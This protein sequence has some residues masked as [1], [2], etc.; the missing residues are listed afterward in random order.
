MIFSNILYNLARFKLSSVAR[1]SQNGIT[2]AGSANGLDGSSLDRLSGSTSA[3]YGDDGILYIS[4]AGNDR[5]VLIAPNSTTPIAVIGRRSDYIIFAYPAAI[6]VTQASIYV[7]DTGNFRVQKWS[8]DFYDPMTVAGISGVGGNSTEMALL[9]AAFSLFVDNYGNVFVSDTD[10]HRVMKFPSNSIS[11]T[12]GMIVAGIGVRGSNNNQL[13]YPMGIFVTNNGILY[14][15]D[16]KNHRIQK[17]IVGQT[18]GEIVGGTGT[19]GSS[20]SQLNSPFSVVV[21]SD[22]YMYITDQGNSRI[23]RWGPHASA[24]ECIVACSGTS[25]ISSNQL[26][27]PTTITFDSIGSMYVNDLSNNRVQKFEILTETSIIFTHE[28]SSVKVVYILGQSTTLSQSTTS[29][30]EDYYFL[31]G[32]CLF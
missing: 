10:N 28:V 12:N 15:A 13:N 20:L 21:D 11:G 2:V 9:S 8:K 24:G 29:K 6:F 26:K 27:H 31:Y 30:I 23:V 4:D 32:H 7:M 1:W 17:W 3:Y 18:S 19:A 5:I 22:G 25:G 16:R 14:I